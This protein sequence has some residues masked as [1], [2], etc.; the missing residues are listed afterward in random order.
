MKIGYL[1]D[2]LYVLTSSYVILCKTQS[3]TLQTLQNF[4][5]EHAFKKNITYINN[6]IRKK[7]VFIYKKQPI[8][9]KNT[10]MQPN[11]DMAKYACFF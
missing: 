11:K 2:A 7:P 4:Y 6:P 10:Y 3:E 8:F 9:F 1:Q 5:L